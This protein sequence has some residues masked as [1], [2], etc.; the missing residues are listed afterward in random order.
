MKVFLQIHIERFHF[1]CNRTSFF[2]KINPM[3]VG[4][5]II[6]NSLSY[7]TTASSVPFLVRFSS[8]KICNNKIG[9]IIGGKRRNEFQIYPY[10]RVSIRQQNI[11]N[12]D[13]KITG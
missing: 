7:L 6:S 9:I 11:R 12:M 8:S 4:F 5:S 2:R 10:M 1:K 13:F 3:S